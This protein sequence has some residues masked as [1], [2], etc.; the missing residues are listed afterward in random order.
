MVPARSVQGK[1]AST[2]VARVFRPGRWPLYLSPL[3]AAAW[4]EEWAWDRCV[5]HDHAALFPGPALVPGAAALALL[6]PLLA[7]PQ[8]T[9]YVLDAWIWR[10]RPENPGLAQHLGF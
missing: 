9:H 6:V 10:V 8:A 3:L 4:L 7:L 2:A 1:R 5:W